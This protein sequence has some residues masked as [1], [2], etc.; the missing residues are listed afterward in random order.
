MNRGI[1]GGFLKA[2]IS[3]VDLDKLVAVEGLRN[4]RKQPE[5]TVFTTLIVVLKNKQNG[6]LKMAPKFHENENK[7]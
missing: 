1:R 6:E 5:D 7:L 2:V 3:A 4:Q